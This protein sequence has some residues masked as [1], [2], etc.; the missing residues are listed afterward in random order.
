MGEWKDLLS[1]TVTLPLKAERETWGVGALELFM[2]AFEF[3]ALVLQH[4]KQNKVRGFGHW[5]KGE[6]NLFFPHRV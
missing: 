1:E 5:K 4:V 2:S 6:L 3:Q